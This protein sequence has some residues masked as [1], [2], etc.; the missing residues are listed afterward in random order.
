M[1]RGTQKGFGKNYPCNYYLEHLSEILG[2]VQPNHMIC[3]STGPD[4]EARADMNVTD[5]RG[6]TPLRLGA[7]PERC[8]EQALGNISS[9]P[10]D[11]VILAFLLCRLRSATERFV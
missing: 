1:E 7:A 6:Q 11:Y 8:R 10:V 3:G 5:K 9:S 4:V 2:K